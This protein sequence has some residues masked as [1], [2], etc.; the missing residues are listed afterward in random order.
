MVENIIREICRNDTSKIADF[1]EQLCRYSCFMC[2]A[3][4]ASAAEGGHFK[5]LKTLKKNI[6][7]S[8]HRARIAAAEFENISPKS[9][10]T[11]ALMKKERYTLAFNF[12]YL[13]GIIKKILGS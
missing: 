11:V 6:L 9:R 13:C 1:E 2:F 7:A 3:I 8:S 10:I 4:L 5:S 12:L